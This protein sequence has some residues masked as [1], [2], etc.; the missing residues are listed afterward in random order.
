MSWNLNVH[1]KTRSAA[2]NSFEAAVDG[3]N[4]AEPKPA[5]KEAARTMATH[6]ADNAPMQIRTY[7]HTNPDGKD[8]RIVIELISF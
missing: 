1:N 4:Y 8:C 2:L 7:G 3:D 6:F 5:I